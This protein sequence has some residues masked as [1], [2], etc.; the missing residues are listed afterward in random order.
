[1]VNIPELQLYDFTHSREAP[2]LFALEIGD[3]MDPSLVGEFRVGQRRVDPTWHVPDS[4]RAE[5]PELPAAVRPGPD[6]PLGRYWLTIG[7][8]SYGIHAA[9]T[10]VGRSGARRRTA[11]CG[12]TRDGRAS[13]PCGHGCL[14][15]SQHETVRRLPRD[16]DREHAVFAQ[17]LGGGCVRRQAQAVRERLD[18]V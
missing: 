12:S 18:S 2:E 8:T 16:R 4:I 14:V 10:T 11:A 6:N 1:M 13:V 15:S 5:K 17:R 3:E 7:R 9:P